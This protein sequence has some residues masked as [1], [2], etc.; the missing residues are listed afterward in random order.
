MN[1]KG[2]GLVYRFTMISGVAFIF[3][4]MGGEMCY[5]VFMK[6]FRNT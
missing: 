2:K 4:N 3:L 1:K 6:T 5:S